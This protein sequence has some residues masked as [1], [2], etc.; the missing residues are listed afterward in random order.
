MDRVLVDTSSWV[1]A[2]RKDRRGEIYRRVRELILEGRAAWCDMVI[3]ELWNGARGDYEKRALKEFEKELERLEIDDTVWV[4]AFELARQC[5]SA[6][7]RFPAPDLL[8]AA[9][10]LAYNVP[11]EHSDSDFIEILKIYGAR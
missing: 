6:G 5:R 4:L 2:F 3:L 1:E 8:I 7:R 10:A 9:C 11:L